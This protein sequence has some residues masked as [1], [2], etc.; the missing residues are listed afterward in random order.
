M[1]LTFGISG[2]M[3]T[4]LGAVGEKSQ[5]LA[6][7]S[8]TFALRRK[9]VIGEE[10]AGRNCLDWNSTVADLDRTLSLCASTELL[11]NAG[12]TD[13]ATRIGFE[14]YAPARGS[15]KRHLKPNGPTHARRSRRR[16]SASHFI[17]LLPYVCARSSH[18]RSSQLTGRPAQM[19]LFNRKQKSDA[20]VLKEQDKKE[21]V[22][23]SRRP[24][25][26]LFD[27]PV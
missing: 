8:I 14:K 24:A 19:G 13:E 5:G 7:E 9:I 15:L 11:S 27:C 3:H 1:Q 21:K 10:T 17:S 20:E 22:K 18:Q 23:W 6:Q 26:E 25:S 4:E 12:E 16:L 2:G